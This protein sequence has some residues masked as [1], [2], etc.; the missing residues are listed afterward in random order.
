MTRRSRKPAPP[1]DRNDLV[2]VL[3]YLGRWVSVVV[4]W[5]RDGPGDWAYVGRFPRRLWEHDPCELYEF[6]RRRTG[7]GRYRAKIYGP[8]D[9]VKRRERFLLQ[10]SF[11]LWEPGV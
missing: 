10:I 8:W 2:D 5:R 4:V 1:V 7:G 3:D 6:V 11:G 9:P